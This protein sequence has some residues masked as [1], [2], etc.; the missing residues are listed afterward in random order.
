M[1]QAAVNAGFDQW[2]VFE[3]I[4]EA[5]RMRHREAYETVERTLAAGFEW[6]PRILDIGCGDGREI[7]KIL[8]RVPATEY[9]GI[10]NSSDVLEN[11][12]VNLA[13][14]PCPWR[15]I[16]G[17][18]TEA[19]KI[20]GTSFNVILLGLFLHH[21]PAREKQDF[22]QHAARMLTADGAVLAHEPVLLETEDRKGFLERMSLACEGWPELTPE[23][24]ETLAPHWSGHG[25]QER[26]SSLEEIAGQAGFSKTE[27]LW[28]DPD[29]FYVVLS[30]RR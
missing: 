24:R 30:F 9:V 10:D 29:R 23:E 14:A 8:K 4:R 25:Y 2:I 13:E 7:A 21:F 27:V 3:K 19:F 16:H 5:N 18:Y 11:A 15:L 20:A 1:K 26:V 12:R 28:R 22:F 17:D 6:P